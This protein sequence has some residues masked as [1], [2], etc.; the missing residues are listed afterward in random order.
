MKT[1]RVLAALLALCMALALFGCG[2]Q[3]LPEGF[4]KDKVTARAEEIVGYANS[5]DYDAIIACLRSDLADAVTADQL[6]EGWAPIYEKVGA[7]DSIQS[8]QFVGTAD[9]TTGEEYAVAV[10]TCKHAS[11]SVTYTVKFDKDLNLVGLYLK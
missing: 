1:K 11:G 4:D 10:V 8:E 6:K 3:S 7:F 5:G 9:K 2:G